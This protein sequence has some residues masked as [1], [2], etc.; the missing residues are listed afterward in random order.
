MFGTNG[1]TNYK[2]DIGTI[3]EF[4]V[5]NV[6]LNSLSLYVRGDTGNRSSSNVVSHLPCT[7]QIIVDEEYLTFKNKDTGAVINQYPISDYV[8]S[9][10]NAGVTFRQLDGSF[11]FKNVKAYP[12]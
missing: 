1:V 9:K 10:F 5:V 11:T 4:D 6:N 7:L 2:F 3:I 8:S 12:I